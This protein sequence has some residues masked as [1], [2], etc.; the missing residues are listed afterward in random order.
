MSSTKSESEKAEKRRDLL[1][2]YL[3]TQA[4]KN[5]LE[6]ENTHLKTENEK[7]AD[8]LAE[9]EREYQNL[10]AFIQGLNA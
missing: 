10:F 6:S 4:A 9:R 3:E 2:A 1:K 7:L 8:Q 5:R